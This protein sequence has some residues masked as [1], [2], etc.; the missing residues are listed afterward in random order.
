MVSGITGSGASSIIYEL[1]QEKKIAVSEDGKTEQSEE[2]TWKYDTVSVSDAARSY[3]PPAPPPD[4]SD[5]DDEELT[6]WLR[7]AE[8]KYGVTLSED[9]SKSAEDLS[10]EEL[11]SI[12]E[13]L[14]AG[15]RGGAGGP[16]GPPPAGG[17]GGPQGA[18]PAGGPQGPPPAGGT[19]GAL[20]A[21]SESDEE[22]SLA[23]YIAALREQLRQEYAEGESRKA[24]ASYAVD[25][26]VQAAIAAYASD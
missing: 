22:E 25:P 3:S 18:P 11:Q 10:A 19:G 2:T 4:F 17:A 7:E 20:A 26:T 15:P 16:Q 5:M 24:S 12:R 13:A 14:S 1:L 23:D 21:E 9:G 8:S 6:A